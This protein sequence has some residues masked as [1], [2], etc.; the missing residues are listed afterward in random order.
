MSARNSKAKAVA[1][2]VVAARELRDA[3]E[4]GRTGLF[5]A[6]LA[7]VV[8]G[9]NME[10]DFKSLTKS[11]YRG[12]KLDH[13]MSAYYVIANA[14]KHIKKVMLSE[15][16]YLQAELNLIADGESMKYSFEALLDWATTNRKPTGKKT[17]PV[18]KTAIQQ[19]KSALPALTVI[20]LESVIAAAR[21]EIRSR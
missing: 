19:V 10:D 8:A 1:G 18:K 3:A 2:V 21:K 20:Q 16:R 9:G 4:A 15:N 7:W 6:V 5:L 11:T 17:A 12:M 13:T 14:F